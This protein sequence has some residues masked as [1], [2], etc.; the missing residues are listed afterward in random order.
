MK[1]G[2][3]DEATCHELVGDER[4][5]TLSAIG[6]QAADIGEG[7]PERAPVQGSYWSQ[8]QDE[9]AYR[10]KLEAYTK[11]MAR[12]SRMADSETRHNAELNGGTSRPT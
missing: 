11:R 5:R 12:I 2:S 6:R 1:P 4:L 9:A 7:P 3:F 10:V 8:V